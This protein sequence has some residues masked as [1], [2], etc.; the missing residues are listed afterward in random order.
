MTDT[1]VNFDR[2]AAVY[3]STRGLPPAAERELIDVLAGELSNRGSCLEV[4]VGTGRPG[5]EDGPLV[6]V[7]AA[8]GS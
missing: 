6:C 1:S 8:I 4:G 5:I 2:A 7:H 3:D